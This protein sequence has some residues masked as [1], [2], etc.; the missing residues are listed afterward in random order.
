MFLFGLS[1]GI[2]A[3][4]SYIVPVAAGWRYFP[5]KKG[6]ISGLTSCA[7]AYAAFTFSIISNRLINP[8]NIEPA[9]SEKQ[10]AV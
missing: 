9:I 1:Q 4:I 5:A 2:G 6:L 7:Y 10:G 3:G 8:D